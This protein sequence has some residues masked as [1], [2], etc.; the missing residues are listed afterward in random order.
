MTFAPPRFRQGGGEIFRAI[1][2]RHCERSEAILSLTDPYRANGPGLLRRC[3]PRNDDWRLNLPRGEQ[4][5]THR[6][7]AIGPQDAQQGDGEAAVGVARVE[8]EGAIGAVGG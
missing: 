5:I 3:A 1:L 8:Q 4:S 2:R 7:A 6:A